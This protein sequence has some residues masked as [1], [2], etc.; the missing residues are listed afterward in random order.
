MKGA[1]EENVLFACYASLVHCCLL[2]HDVRLALS[3]HAV[4]AATQCGA[5]DTA[6]AL[7]RANRARRD[8]GSL[9]MSRMQKIGG[10]S[11][12]QGAGQGQGLDHRPLAISSK[13]T[14]KGSRSRRKGCLVFQHNPCAQHAVPRISTDKKNM[15]SYESKH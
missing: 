10:R 8:P 11:F 3:R 13:Q 6:C 2:K 15:L 9:K 4:R 7:P 14:K 1:Y 12:G 5:C